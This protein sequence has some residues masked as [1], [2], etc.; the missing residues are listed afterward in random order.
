MNV[1]TNA[2]ADAVALLLL[3]LLLLFP[4]ATVVAMVSAIDSLVITATGN[5]TRNFFCWGAPEPRLD[6]YICYEYGCEH[7]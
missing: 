5:M 7:S 4:P 1:V 6:R 3:L 2:N